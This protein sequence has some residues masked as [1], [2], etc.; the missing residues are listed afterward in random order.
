MTGTIGLKMD[1]GPVGG[2][3]GRG[4]EA[5]KLV[6]MLK[7]EKVKITDILVPYANFKNATDEMK[8]V[9]DEGINVHPITNAHEGWPILFSLNSEELAKKIRAALIERESLVD[10]EST[11]A[12]FVKNS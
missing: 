10:I 2:L 12:R 3:G 5:G 8:V 4:R 7:A 9:Q 6:G 11:A 1:V